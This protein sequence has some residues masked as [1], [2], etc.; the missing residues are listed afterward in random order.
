MEKNTA[1]PGAD[2]NYRRGIFG[3][4]VDTKHVPRTMNIRVC[5]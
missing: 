4:V 3:R 1:F 2:W 5:G